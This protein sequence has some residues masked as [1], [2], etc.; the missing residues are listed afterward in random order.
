M[1][2]TAI[3]DTVNTAARLESSAEKDKII[4]SDATYQHVKDHIEATDMGILNVKNKR[5]GIKI[6]SV[7]NVI[8]E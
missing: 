7:D 2:Y 8:G 1:E 5:V 6:Y 4:I 3:G